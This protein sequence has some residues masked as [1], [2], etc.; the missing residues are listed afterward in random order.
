M[1]QELAASRSCVAFIFPCGGVVSPFCR[2]GNRGQQVTDQGHEGSL[3]L[4]WELNSG[5]WS[6][7]DKEK[8][9]GKG[10]E[11]QEAVVFNGGKA[12]GPLGPS[13]NS[14]RVCLLPKQVSLKYWHS[15]FT[16]KR[17]VDRTWSLNHRKKHSGKPK[18]IPS[19]P[20]K[21]SIDP[22]LNHMVHGMLCM[23]RY[24]HDFISVWTH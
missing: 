16:A 6:K 10:R 12:L 17:F 11:S 19:L 9:R 3:W 21:K 8:G 15:Y 1:P 13:S 18:T 14:M 22:N 20:G 4:G 7:V 24:L 5:H 2:Q 23:Q